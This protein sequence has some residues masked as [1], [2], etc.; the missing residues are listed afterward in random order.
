MEKL[1]PFLIVA[2]GLWTAAAALA[3]GASLTGSI[4]VALWSALA[5]MKASVVTLWAIMENIAS[6]ERLRVEA[7]ADL[8][9]GPNMPR[10]RNVEPIR[11]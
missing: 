10:Q 1:W 2:T 7:I 3:V 9:V 4:A 8:L 11:H 6:R 5:A